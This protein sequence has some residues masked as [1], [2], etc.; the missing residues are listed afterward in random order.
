MFPEL[1]SAKIAGYLF[2]A[3][4]FAKKIQIAERTLNLGFNYY[5]QAL[6]GFGEP[7]FGSKD[8]IGLGVSFLA[9]VKLSFKTQLTIDVISPHFSYTQNE[10]FQSALDR[11]MGQNLLNTLR[12]PLNTGLNSPSGQLFSNPFLQKTLS[13]TVDGLGGAPASLDLRNKT[14]E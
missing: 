7:S 2:K 14:T 4:S 11:S 12:G 13:S 6:S 8:Q 10:G 3:N 1:A 9:P 5:S